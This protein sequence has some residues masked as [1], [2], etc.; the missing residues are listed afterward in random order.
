MG[1]LPLA[2]VTASAHGLLDLPP[3][4]PLAVAL[5]YLVL[6][7]L[8][9]ASAPPALPP[10]GIGWANRV[11]LFRAVLTLPVAGLVVVP[12]GWSGGSA[13]W[14]VTLASVALSL[15]GLDGAVARATRT[16]TAF[17]A[18]FDM[19]LDAFLILVL[20]W[21]VWTHTPLGPWVLGIG[22]IRYAF[23]AAGAFWPALRGALPPSWRR[24][25]I[26][27]VQSVALLLA[28]APPVPGAW[29]MAAAAS[30]LALLVYSF[31]VDVRWLFAH[32]PT[33]TVSRAP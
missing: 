27:V 7:S 8:L 2:A 1:A 28:L 12:G 26:C 3:V 24:K 17:G 31:A 6:V 22:L 33:A 4:Y 16:T 19:E 29:A 5:A 13:W 30:A 10:P 9:T 18:R 11:T 14:G 25:V 15:D 21:L 32:A 20:S 23:V